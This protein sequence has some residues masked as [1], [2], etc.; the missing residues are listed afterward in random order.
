MDPPVDPLPRKPGR[1]FHRGA[2]VV[3]IHND[4]PRVLGVAIETDGA[5]STITADYY[6]A[7]LPGEVTTP[8]LARVE[9]GCVS[10]T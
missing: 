9:A 4:G 7:A 6:I 1:A 3:G 2:R 10:P 5:S 8:L